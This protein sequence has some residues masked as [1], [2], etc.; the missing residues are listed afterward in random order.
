MA[1]SSADRPQPL[2]YIAGGLTGAKRDLL[3]RYELIRDG[4]RA[5]GFDSYLPHQDTGPREADISPSRVMESNLSALNRSVAVVAELTIPSHGV[6]IE[7]HH[8]LLRGIPVLG[9]ARERADISKMVRGHPALRGDIARY[10]KKEEIPRLVEQL[11]KGEIRAVGKAR[12]RIIAVEGPD[13]VGKSTLVRKLANPIETMTGIKPTIVTDP[14]WNVSPWRELRN[15]FRKEERLS[16][17]AEALLYLTARVDNYLRN[18][19][20][21]LRSGGVVLA[22]RWVDSWLAYQAVRIAQEADKVGAAIEFLL[23]QEMLLESFEDIELA[24]LS[25]LLMGQTDALFERG[26]A[27]RSSLDKYE[28]SENIEAVS[29]AYELLY[30]RFS[31]RIVRIETTGRNEEEVLRIATAVVEDYFRFHGLLGIKVPDGGAKA[32]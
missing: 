30:S 18:V 4:C 3:G 6:G 28:S 24:G 10:R 13:F 26:V 9:I 12:C 20:A 25:L 29:R 27:T 1:A 11:L 32:I 22:D 15:V 19:R 23:A 7:I 21:I 14:P 5:A 8:A 17:E 16:R 31:H 2:V